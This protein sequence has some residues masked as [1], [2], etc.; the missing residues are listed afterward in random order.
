[1]CLLNQK[2]KNSSVLSFPVINIFKR[3]RKINE[4]I[5]EALG[6]ITMGAAV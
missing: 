1:M 4:N 3:L 6:K 2:N 5:S